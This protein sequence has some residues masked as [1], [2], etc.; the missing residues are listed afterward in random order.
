MRDFVDLGLYPGKDALNI[1]ETAKQL[2]YSR[3]GLETNEKSSTIDLVSRVDLHP[4]NQNDLGKQLRRLR[5]KVEVIIV[6]GTTKSVSR[7]AAHDNRVDFMRFPLSGGKHLQYL[8]RQQAGLM[9]DSGA[10]YEV[11]VRDLLVEDRFQLVKRIGIIKK[12]LDI[13]MKHDLPV[14]ASSGAQDMYGMRDPHGLASLLSLLGV[15][16]ETGLD[17]VS[18][19]PN[20][21]IA[22]NRSKLGPNFIEPGVWIIDE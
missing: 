18:S 8:D 3:V 10:G 19:I 14:V 7:Q 11:C 12:S 9:R 2:G 21:V 15:D 1:I 6:H 16:D 4:R 13:A 5:N 20:G 22:E 17:M